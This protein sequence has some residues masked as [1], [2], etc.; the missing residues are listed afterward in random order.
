[1]NEN[2]NIE[3]SSKK[4]LKIFYEIGSING[5]SDTIEFFKKMEKK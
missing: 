5:L 2:N 3:L 1:M 4:S